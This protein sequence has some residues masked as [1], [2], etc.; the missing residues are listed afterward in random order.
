[1]EFISRGALLLVLAITTCWKLCGITYWGNVK[2]SEWI[3]QVS[4]LFKTETSWWTC[5]LIKADRSQLRMVHGE[6]QLLQSVLQWHCRAKKDIIAIAYGGLSVQKQY[7]AN[8][9]DKNI[10]TEYL[11]TE[12][13][14]CGSAYSYWQCF[15]ERYCKCSQYCT[16]PR[17]NS[18]SGR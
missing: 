8:F 17:L 10:L 7:W 18:Y 12:N 5:G 3:L 11:E 16:H 9:P 15:D 1:M 14:P 2:C 13:V 6:K 4:Y